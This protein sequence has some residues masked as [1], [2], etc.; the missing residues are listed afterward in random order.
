MQVTDKKNEQVAN[1]IFATIYPHYWNRLDKHGRTREEFH[2]VIEW[3]T[4]YDEDKLQS[5]LADKVSYRTFFE[6]AKIHPNAHMIKG[7]VCGY[8]IEE[9]ED[10]YEVYKRS[11]QLEKLIDELAR[12]R[13]MERILREEKK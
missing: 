5:L 3:Y 10:K 8:R 11:R 13:K 12:G 7:V 2:R 1:M 9:I 4:G 6:E